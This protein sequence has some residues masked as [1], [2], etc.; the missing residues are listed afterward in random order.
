MDPSI[1]KLL[2]EDEDDT[3]HSGAD[4]DA[5]TA[6]LNRDIEGDIST[7]Q[8]SDSDS[9]VLSHN[10]NPTSSQLFLQWPISRQ[11]EN[12]TCQNQQE[13]KNVQPQEEYPSEADPMQFGTDFNNQSSEEHIQLPLQQ[14]QSNDDQK[15]HQEEQKSL[16]VSQKSGVKISEQ[17]PLHFSDQDKMQNADSQHQ[18]PTLYKMS[19]Q[20]APTADQVMS[21]GKQ[22]SFSLL[23]PVLLPHLDKDRA[24]QLQTLSTKLR[25]NEIHKEGFIRLMKSIVGDHMLRQALAKVRMQELIKAQASRNPQTG[26]HHFQFQ[27]QT[28]SQHQQQQPPPPPLKMPSLNASQFTDPLSFAQLHQN[29]HKSPTDLSRVPTSTVQTQSNSTFSTTENSAQM[30]KDSE[31]QLDS[32]GTH[33]SQISSANMSMIK[34]EKE[35]PSIPMQG[36]NKPQQQH[37]HLPQTSFAMYGSAVSN[38]H[39]AHAYSGPVISGT[40]T[41]HKS[42]T[43]DSQMR[44]VSLHQG[45]TS[46]QLGGATRP[47]NMMSVPKYEMQNSINESKR[48]PGGSLPHLSSHSTLQQSPVPWQSSIKEHKTVIPSS[49]SYVKQEQNDQT[50]EQ[51]HKSQLSVPQGSSFATIQ[52]EQ[53]ETMDKQSTMMTFSTST[54]IGPT[55]SVLGTMPAQ[56][57]SMMRT[58][59]PSAATPVGAGLS[60]KTPLKKPSVGQK[61]PLEA[62]GTSV[63]SS[64]KKQKVSGAFLDQSI[65]QLNDVT[66]VSGVNLRE[67]EEQLFSGSKEESRASEATRRVV[68]EE[69]E[70]LI[71]Q[72]IPLQKKLTEIMSKCGIKSV[73]SDVERC[74]SL[75]VEERMRGLISNLIRLSKQRVDIEKPRH[76]TLIT[77]DVRCQIIMMN[78]K[79]KEEWDKKQAE[80]AEKLRKLNEAEGNTGVDG[81]KDKDEGRLK[82]QKANKEEDDKMRTTAANV[83]ARAAVGGDDMLSKWQLMA[84]QARQKREGRMD[85]ASCVQLGKDLS[86]RPL[87]TSGRATKDNQD[88]ENKGP[89]SSAV[90]SGPMRKFGRSHVVMTQTKVARFISVKDVIAVLE[91][92]PQMSKSTLIY[93][94]YEKMND[95]VPSAK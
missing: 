19:N 9:V 61:K 62:L 94:L 40:T 57:E 35:L 18:Y 12:I 84:E 89:S 64:S 5:F 81:D 34:Q 30:S 4:V 39:A 76:P 16:Q 86:Q 72:K 29:S 42:Q 66:A 68:Q 22:I 70:R 51:Q 41:S 58:Q 65:E 17:N 3:I 56:L 14:K 21:R 63:P 6:A 85:V 23:L 37:L 2:E 20:Q 8:P 25:K 48:L 54:S 36:L 53:E 69:E 10:I 60:A 50:A 15:Q 55:N 46:T 71:L 67:E 75:S 79:A 31:N 26:S 45:M 73:S 87:S 93:R 27:S 59:I 49:V 95:A 88:A 91:R 38:Y 52:T 24:M 74:L 7:S 44:Q 77:S 47:M 80:E 43:Q 33:A 82:A 1:M 11:K 32:Q 28:S 83:A 90:A 78:R 13:L 92:E